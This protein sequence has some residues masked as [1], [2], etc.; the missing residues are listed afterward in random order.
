MSTKLAKYKAFSP[1]ASVEAAA[2]ALE[3]LQMQKVWQTVCAFLAFSLFNK[4]E[5]HIGEYLLQ[6]FSDMMGPET[7]ANAG[8]L[9]QSAPDSGSGRPCLRGRLSRKR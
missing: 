1:T 7:L 4:K 5:T 6:L 9:P 2:A 3:Q 8:K